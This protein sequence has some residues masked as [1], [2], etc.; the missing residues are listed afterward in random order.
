MMV[1]ILLVL[2]FAAYVV[3]TKEDNTSS[4]KTPE[5]T[6][7]LIHA[8]TLDSVP[9]GADLL[10]NGSISGSP[11][12]TLKL[13]KDESFSIRLVLDGYADREF[14]INKDTPE[15][16]TIQL[17]KVEITPPSIEPIKVNTK[18]KAPAKVSPKP[19]AK[20]KDSVKKIKK[21]KIEKKGEL[22]ETEW[23]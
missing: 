3:Q 23:D 8:I 12:A 2:G 10:R 16:M 11:P 9:S 6:V 19:K 5:N 15:K 17:R 7:E 1:I 13:E 4:T 14:T 20:K 18:K 21:E 22:K